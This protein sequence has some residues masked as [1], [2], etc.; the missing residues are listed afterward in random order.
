MPPNLPNNNSQIIMK[1]FPNPIIAPRIN[2]LLHLLNMP[3]QIPMLTSHRIN[4]HLNP[5]LLH[6]SK[7]LFLHHLMR[8][9][10]LTQPPKNMQ[11]IRI[12]NNLTVHN[13]IQLK[14][15]PLNT[16]VLQLQ[17]MYRIHTYTKKT[18]YLIIMKLHFNP[19]RA[20]LP[21]PPKSP[22]PKNLIIPNNQTYPTLCPLGYSMPQPI[23]ILN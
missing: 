19:I 1:T 14:K 9:P 10:Q 3:P 4:R 8:I 6:H 16:N 5:L 15:L 20:N 2:R 23:I 11:Q 18:N 17:S 7:N 21:N 13:R 12:I 22:P